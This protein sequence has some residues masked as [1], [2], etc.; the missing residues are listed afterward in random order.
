MANITEHQMEKNMDSYR[1]TG[2]IWELIAIILNSYQYRG[3][4][5]L[6]H[7]IQFFA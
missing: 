6:W 2:R 7:T 5:C 1:E 3:E 4:V